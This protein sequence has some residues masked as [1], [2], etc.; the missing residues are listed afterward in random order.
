MAYYAIAPILC[1]L[2]Q[3]ELYM[4][5]YINQV[6]AGQSTNQLVV[7]TSSQPQ[8]FGIT[9]IND[10]PITDGANTVGRAQGLHF[11]SGQTSQKWFSGSSLQVM[12]TIPQDGEW[13]IIGGTGEFVAAQGIVEHNV[14]Q[15]AAAAALRAA[16]PAGH[17]W[18]HRHPLAAV[19]T[20]KR[21]PSWTGLLEWVSRRIPTRWPSSRLPPPPAVSCERRWNHAGLL[22]TAAPVRTSE[23]F[24]VAP[25]APAAGKRVDAGREGELNKRGRRRVL[26]P[27]E[28]NVMHKRRRQKESLSPPPL[29]C[30]G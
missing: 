9:V 3:N 22:C 19:M 8:G 20:R 15:E 13:S 14:I 11:Q 28:G 23:V 26:P 12:G 27:A 16:P 17:P 29:N 30:D 18:R 5:L 24:R 4:H 6:Y 25:E 7:I 10:W 1:A 2:V 21:K